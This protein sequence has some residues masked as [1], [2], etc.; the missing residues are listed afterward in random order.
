VS[1]D[2][3]FRE[4]GDRLAGRTVSR[5]GLLAGVAG[6]AAGSLLLPGCGG[7]SDPDARFQPKDCGIGRIDINVCYAPYRVVRSE[8]ADLLPKGYKGVAIRK[9]PEPDAPIIYKEN[10]PCIMRVGGAYG[11]QSER[12]GGVDND[13]PAPPERAGMGAGR[14]FY[15]GYP[16]R[17][18]GS[19]NKGGWIAG[20]V[21]GVTYSEPYPDY[22]GKFCGPASLDFDCRAGDD[23][24]SPYKLRCGTPN[25][26][27]Y[28]CGG[29]GPYFG[30]C[31]AP[32]MN[33]VGIY[34]ELEPYTMLTSLSHERYNLKYEAD[35]VTIFW[36]V[37]GDTVLR[38]CTKCTDRN[39]N[40]RCPPQTYDPNKK[41]CCRSYTCVEVVSARY[42]P[43]GIT[44][45]I[46]TSVL[47]DSQPQTQADIQRALTEANGS[48]AGF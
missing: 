36:L 11:R 41:D 9:G 45:W 21:D 24:N 37:P 43:K 38:Y 19:L 23:P 1:L 10:E 34:E 18:S 35:S 40:K 3:L 25:R 33:Y 31:H 44:G 26:P 2:A 22:P 28:R 17:S 14:G 30:D 7:G 29:G 39:P 15:W 16:A 48:F 42:C 32:R 12:D 8:P 46:N 47:F 27:R 6:T 4:A 20:V 5:R 13:C